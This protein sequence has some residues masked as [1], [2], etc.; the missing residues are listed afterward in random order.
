MAK[1]PVWRSIEQA[2]T[3]EIAQGHY[4]PGDK[5]PTEAELSRRF[6]VNRHT[7]RRA[8]SALNDAGL[9][10]PKR[11]AGVFVSAEPTN[12]RIGR[13]VRFSQNLAELGQNA[14]REILS[15]E[16]RTADEREAQHLNLPVGA[17]VHVVQTISFAGKAPLALSR[18]VFPA[19]RLPGLLAQV[20]KTRSITAGLRA[21]GVADYTR[22]KTWLAAKLANATQAAHL[23]IRQGDPILRTIS[24]NVEGNNQPVEYGH[25]WFAG[26]RVSLMVDPDFL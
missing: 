6:G 21:E 5:L 25:T 26:D 3:S 12:Y 9:V 15:A 20:R 2:L 22:A 23:H 19:D 18:H 4:I 7:V 13:R 11:G 14:Q 10:L 16:T 17:Q 1:T 24:V 8:L